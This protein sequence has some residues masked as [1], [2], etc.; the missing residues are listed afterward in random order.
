MDPKFL[1][2]VYKLK[3]ALYGLHQDP[4]AWYETLSTYLLDNGFHRGQIDKTLF[5]KRLKD[6]ILL[7]QGLKFQQREDEIFIN[8]DKYV[9]EILKKFS[10]FSIRSASTPIET[11]KP[12][13]KEE[14]GE[15]V[16]VYLYRSMIRSL[17]YLTSSR[18]DIMFSV[19]AC[20][21]FQVRPQVSYL[22]A[23]KRIF[24]YLKGQPELGLWYP[25]DSPLILEAFSNTDYAGASLDRK[26]KI[27]R[28][29][30]LGSRLISWQCKNQNVVANSTTE[31]EYITTSHCCGQVLWI[32]NKMLDYGYNTM[33]TKIHVDNESSI[34]VI[35]N[36][37]YHS[38]T[39]HIKIRHH[40]I[41]DSY[42]TD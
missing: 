36:H 14:N 4:R 25:K 27:V 23:V 30:F 17:M 7:V 16:D 3:K 33:Q 22:H 37:I 8:Q 11:H 38:K 32:Q 20:S 2:K 13:I 1:E 34:Y 6:D 19:C 35:K 41:R 24:R 10:L 5:I 21:R 18:P 39:K 9:G 40:F 12:L 31:A 28:C 29:Q 42:E 26:S 15:D